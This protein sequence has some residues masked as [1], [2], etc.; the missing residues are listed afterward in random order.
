KLSYAADWSEYAGWRDGG[1]AIFHL[2]P[3][4]ADA[5]IDYVGIDWYP[6]LADW[7]DGDGGVDAPVFDGPHD[8]ERL[9]AQVA[10][11]EGFDWFYASDEDR[12]L[13]LRT[14]ISDMAHGEDWVFRVKDL[15]GW[16]SNPHHDRPGG[17]RSATP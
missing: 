1:K 2:D 15:K 5:D 7:R 4:W 12:D 17:V 16:W 9:R 11:A 6:P 13:Q 14:P 8:P 3:L 10:G